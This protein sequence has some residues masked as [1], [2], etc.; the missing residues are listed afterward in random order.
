MDRLRLSPELTASPARIVR[1]R[2][3]TAHPPTPAQGRKDT[4]MDIPAEVRAFCEAHNLTESQFYG[5]E[6]VPGNLDLR[7]LTTLPDGC[8]LNA[9]GYIDLYNL[10]TLPDGCALNA[11][12]YID[13]RNLTTLP[14]GCSLIAG[15][16][17]LMGKLT[18]LPDGCSL[19]AGGSLYLGNLTTLP[20]DCSLT[21]GEAIYLANLTTLP[22]DC[23][24]TAGGSLYLYNL[25]TLPEGCPLT[26]GGSLYL[27]DRATRTTNRPP[28]MLSWYG[29]KYVMADG[30]LAEVVSRRGNVYRVRIVGQRDISVMATDGQGRWAHGATVA[31]A[32][33]DLAY[34]V[35]DRDV[36]T[37]AGQAITDEMTFAQAV[38]CYRVITG[39]CAKGVQAFV[40][41]SGVNTQRKFSAA[42]MIGMTKGEYGHDTFARFWANK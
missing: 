11:G 31:K 41:R 36:S 1:G 42:D 23:S 38:E 21:A 26:A 5:R 6:P 17:I 24:L 13:L 40:Q 39:A 19:I 16:S 37:Y 15:G 4:I 22:D 2:A 30:I 32:R 12:G 3:L 18:A 27:R 9:G 14:K 28:A 20:D 29:G 10:T 25:T 8:A 33:A 35:S 7:K 34:K